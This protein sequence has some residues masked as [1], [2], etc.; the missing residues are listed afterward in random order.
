MAT[1]IPLPTP[2]PPLPR[3]WQN[4][5]LALALVLLGFALFASHGATVEG[6]ALNDLMTFF[7]WINALDQRMVPSVDFQ[8]PVGVLAHILPWLG[9]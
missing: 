8:T 4:P 5:A 3:H 9:S 2:S 6:Y 1:N 7:G